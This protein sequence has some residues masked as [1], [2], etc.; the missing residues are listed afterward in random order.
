MRSRK[1]CAEITLTLAVP[2]LTGPKCSPSAVEILLYYPQTRTSIT[3]PL[4]DG[5][6]ELLHCKKPGQVTN[7]FLTIENNHQKSCQSCFKNTLLCKIRLC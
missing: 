4:T 5:K 7:V 6:V 1:N 2:V 3:I